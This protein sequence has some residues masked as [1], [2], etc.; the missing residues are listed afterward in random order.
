[1][2]MTVRAALGKKKMLDKQI[3]GMVCSEFFCYCYA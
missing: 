2:E 1:M 3:D